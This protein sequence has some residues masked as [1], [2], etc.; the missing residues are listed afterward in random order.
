MRTVLLLSI[1]CGL[2][3]APQAAA[4]TGQAA[5]VEQQQRADASQPMIVAVASGRTFTGELDARTDQDRLWL[6][7]Q[8]GSALVL[9]PL[10]WDRVLA[11][12]VA[13]EELSGEAFRGLVRQFRQTNPAP[14]SPAGTKQLVLNGSAGPE[15][16]S[17][18]SP[19]PVRPPQTPRVCSLAI[20]AEVARWNPNVEADGLL[21]HVYPLGADG[22]V[23]PVRGT[24]EVEWLGRRIDSVNP[25]TAFSRQAHWE[26][27]VHEEDFGLEGAVYRLPFQSVQP[28]FDLAVA[29]YGAVHARLSVPGQSTFEA[30][31]G[32]VRVR[33]PSPVR[34][35]LQ[36]DT[37][38]R[39]FPQETTTDGRH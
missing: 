30:T 29:R 18:G 6:R 22:G 21:V 35:Q 5:A 36:L 2:A 37:G 12:R 33:P 13:G 28:E 17:A 26:V 19:P 23:V 34:D 8:Q 7:R 27:P 39:F 11:V 16:W 32:T 25:A 14:A 24:L 4:E 1:L 20:D 10:Q 15:D 9:R 31:A 38:H 3:A